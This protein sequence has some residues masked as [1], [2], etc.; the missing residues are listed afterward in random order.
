MAPLPGVRG[1]DGF[2][3]KVKVR[4]GDPGPEWGRDQGKKAATG[5]NGDVGRD[6]SSVPNLIPRSLPSECLEGQNCSVR[7]TAGKSW[8]RRTG[9]VSRPGSLGGDVMV[10]S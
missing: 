8:G 6:E 9:N 7:V 4:A 2:P 1:V 5:P 3:G 10:E